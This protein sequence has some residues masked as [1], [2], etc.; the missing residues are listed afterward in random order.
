MN[1]ARTLKQTA[2]AALLAGA[3]MMAPTA[4]NASVFF[5][6]GFAPPAIPVYE[7]PLCP[8][9]GYIWTPGYWAWTGD[10]YEWV[11]GA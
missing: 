2:G 8:G 4:A 5:S 9:D 1:I 10:G 6:V 11:D 3:L 7:Q